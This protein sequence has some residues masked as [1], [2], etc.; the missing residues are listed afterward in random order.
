VVTT[1]PSTTSPSPSLDEL[2]TIAGSVCDPELPPLT[3]V[4]LG[5]LRDVELVDDEVVVTLTPT[6]S[7]CPAV[8]YIEDEVRRALEAAGCQE[9]RIERAFTPSWT[10]DWI[11]DEGR[12][13]M[14]E[15]G[16]A[17]PQPTGSRTG[18]PVPVTLGRKQAR[19]VPCPLCGATTTVEVSPFGST[20]CKA[21]YR[22]EACAEPFDYFKEI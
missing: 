9:V 21:H 18:E 3:L 15:A 4:D 8:E 19:V 2:R 12:R 11:T 22:C 10:T 13:K 7:G 17:P 6:Y 1:V 14:T 16:I 5:I 20:A